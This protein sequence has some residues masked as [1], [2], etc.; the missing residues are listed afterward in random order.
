MA[1]KFSWWRIVS[2]PECDCYRAVLFPFCS[3]SLFPIVVVEKLEFLDAS[4]TYHLGDAP[5]VEA[6]KAK[7]VSAR[8]ERFV[9]LRRIQAGSTF[10]VVEFPSLQWAIYFKASRDNSL[11]SN[12]GFCIGFHD[13]DENYKTDYNMPSNT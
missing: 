5:P 10:A 11:Y 8:R 4:G 12:E 9:I 6:F 3:V 13:L 7:C 1:M 2:H